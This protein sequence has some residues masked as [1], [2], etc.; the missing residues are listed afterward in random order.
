[1]VFS[2]CSSLCRKVKWKLIYP[3]HRRAMWKSCEVFFVGYPKTG[4]TWLRYQLGL[5]SQY[6]GPAGEP[7]RLFDGWDWLGRCERV[8]GGPA[9]HFTHHPLTWEKQTA[10][11]LT[12]GNVVKPFGDKRIVLLVR[13]PLDALLSAWYQETKRVTPPYQGSF[14]EFA[15]DPVFGLDKFIK[16]Y[17]LWA[18]AAKNNDRILLV[19]YENQRLNN[20]DSLTSVLRFLGMEVHAEI[21]DRAIADASF[22]SMQSIEKKGKGPVYKSSMQSIFATN[23]GAGEE[24]MHVRRGVIGGYLDLLPENDRIRLEQKISDELD[25]IYGYGKQVY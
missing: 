20:L 22:E 24:G 15:T 6:S 9:C 11:E 8:W 10:L 14:I 2:S 19:S 17:N 25:P 7:L 13:T 1:M 12:H 5:V 4:N 21:V 16:F 23:L 18:E 3:H